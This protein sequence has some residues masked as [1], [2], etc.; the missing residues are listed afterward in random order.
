MHC[1]NL[2]TFILVMNLNICV[3]S[4]HH[5]DIPLQLKLPIDKYLELSKVDRIKEFKTS[6]QL[7]GGKWLNSALFQFSS[8]RKGSLKVVK[9]LVGL[10]ANPRYEFIVSETHDTSSP[11]YLAHRAFYIRKYHIENKVKDESWK[12]K[13]ID[14]N[15]IY[16]YY[17]DLIKN[18]ENIT[19]DMLLRLY[20]TPHLNSGSRH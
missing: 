1:R 6:I 20:I 8:G 4:S 18:E 9:E 13:F 2:I 16:E 12:R 7:H 5:D 10:G 11:L 15:L 3:A 14:G 17:V 19:D